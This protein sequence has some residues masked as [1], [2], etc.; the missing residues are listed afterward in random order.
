MK[1]ETI[2]WCFIRTFINS[3]S[4]AEITLSTQKM[5]ETGNYSSLSTSVGKDVDCSQQGCR[6]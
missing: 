5:Q 6:Q 1:K 2:S 4:K 3:C